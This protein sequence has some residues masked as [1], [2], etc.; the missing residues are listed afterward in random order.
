MS[1]IITNTPFVFPIF[2]NTLAVPAERVPIWNISMPLR[3]L[4]MNAAGIDPNK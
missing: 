3:L 1:I 4:T 2:L